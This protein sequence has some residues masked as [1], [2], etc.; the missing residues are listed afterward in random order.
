[1]DTLQQQLSLVSETLD[2]WVTLQR[3]WEHLQQI[4]AY[5]D[6]RKQMPSESQKFQSVDNE[7]VAMCIDTRDNPLVLPA[8]TAE[9][10]LQRIQ[11]MIQKLEEVSRGLEDY[12]QVTGSLKCVCKAN[13][14]QKL[15]C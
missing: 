7:F 5:Q 6:L 8:C 13:P 12:L 11:A 9:G 1:M 10:K 3:Q 15:T 2:E 14:E 4:F